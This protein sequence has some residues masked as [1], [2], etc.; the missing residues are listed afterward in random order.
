MPYSDI[1]YEKNGKTAVLTLNRP[2]D[3]NV[4]TGE[5]FLR[6]FLDAVARVQADTELC[7]FILTGAGTAFSAGGDVK[8]MR[9]KTGMFAGAP[10]EIAGNYRQG[11]QKIPLALY[12]LD[13]PA[14]AAV[15]G[16]AIGAGCDLACVCDIR[17]ASENAKFGETF[18]SLGLIPGDGGAFFLPR[19]VGWSRAAEL[20]FTCRVIGAAEALAMGLVSEVVPPERLMERARALA[21]EIARQGAATLRRAKALLR[22]ARRMDLPELLDRSAEVQGQCH[23]GEEHR[24][25]LARFFAKKD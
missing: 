18:A 25:A 8:A 10:E 24:E 12:A 4:L 1:L 16:P 7:A 6:E 9:D 19:T 5:R 11:I 23:H 17:I 21:A 15:N 13:V 14:I 3:R 22:D 20:T 2:Q